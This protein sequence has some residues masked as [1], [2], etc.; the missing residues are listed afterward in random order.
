MAKSIYVGLS[1]IATFPNFIDPLGRKSRAQIYR[2]RG[3]TDQ[4]PSL[5][6]GMRH[7]SIRPFEIRPIA[8]ARKSARCLGF[9]AFGRPVNLIEEFC[10]RIDLSPD[11]SRYFLA[12]PRIEHF[13][14]PHRSQ[15]RETKDHPPNPYLVAQIESMHQ[16]G[17]QRGV[18]NTF[19][20]SNRRAALRFPPRSRRAQS[21]LRQA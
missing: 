16:I 9:W 17:P 20:R 8:S 10:K 13:V 18:G 6:R 15:Y 3:I 1:N 14:L 21:R 2:Q 12:M 7:P 5:E 4:P 19:P 11:L